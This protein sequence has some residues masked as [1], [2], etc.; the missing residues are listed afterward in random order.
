MLSIGKLGTGGDAA[1]YYLDLAKAA[2]YT[3]SGEPP[4]QWIGKGSSLLGL[5]DQV[6]EADLIHMMQ[7]Y[8]PQKGQPLVQM[9]KP[10]AAGWDLTFSAP[11]SV[12]IAWALGEPE[13]RD[14]IEKAQLAAVEKAIQYLESTAITRLGKG[15]SEKEKPVGLIAASFQHSCSRE[16]DPQ[17]HTHTLIANVCQRP[18]GSTGTIES[19]TFFAHKM[20]AGAIYRAELASS[21]RSQGFTLEEDVKESFKISGISKECCQQFS[22][23]RDDIEAYLEKRGLSDPKSSAIASLATRSNKTESSLCQKIGDWQIEASPFGIDAKSIAGLQTFSQSSKEIP[24]TE[25]ILSELTEKSS[26][27]REQD[28]IRL[29]AIKSQFMD[30]DRELLLKEIKQSNQ[31]INLSPYTDGQKRYTSIEM[32]QIEQS[33]LSKALAGKD[34]LT[35]HLSEKLVETEISRIAIKNGFELNKEQGEAVRYIAQ[36]SGTIACIEGMAGTG[37]TTALEAINAVYQSAGYQVIGCALSGKAAEGLEEGSGIKSSTIHSLLLRLERK[38]I[39]LNEQSVIIVDEA[40][41]VGSRLYHALVENAHKAG[42]KLVLVGDYRQLQPIDAG[43]M[44]KQITLSLGSAE[45]VEIRRQ[46]EE[47]HKEAIHHVVAGRSAEAIEAFNSRG[48]IDIAPNKGEAI[49]HLVQDWFEDPNSHPN[50][51]MLAG[52]R[53]ETRLCNE[54]ARQ[55]L[56]A[57]GTINLS[58]SARISCGDGYE[59]EFCVGDR[60]LFSKNHLPLGVKNGTAGHVKNI[61]L[62]TDGNTQFQV[63]TDSSETVNF[64]TEDYNHLLHGYCVSVHKSQGATVNKTYLLT[65]ERMTD[66]EWSYVALSRSRGD[67]KIYTIQ[68]EFESLPD[69]LA[70]SHQKDS[71]IDYESEKIAFEYSSEVSALPL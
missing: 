71:S 30:F 39:E 60:I 40:G 66:R 16:D 67:T 14:A 32:W 4:G 56:K 17:L 28:L 23:R 45:L 7:G 65:N 3:D 49:E 6:D 8:H 24:T 58:V 13:L 19:S 46:K 44:F 50:K 37:K 64:R 51:I 1:K 42:A 48:L 25:E 69:R 38:E 61:Y 55:L 26:T 33:I 41:M 52:T 59:R 27:F 2:Y 47:W 34:S 31:L 12:S 43:G 68:D 36:K 11:K 20:T 53:Y 35:H 62:D 18:D 9:T 29:L 63:V 10:H 54:K 70:T 22:K 57:N 15:G 21:L 5:K